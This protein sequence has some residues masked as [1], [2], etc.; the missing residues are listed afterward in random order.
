[1]R[2][3]CL[4]FGSFLLFLDYDEEYVGKLFEEVVTHK[5]FIGKIVINNLH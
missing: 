1:M 2:Y 5:I 4:L 3:Y